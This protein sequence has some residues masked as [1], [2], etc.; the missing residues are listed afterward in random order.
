[1]NSN[2]SIQAHET[3]EEKR[4]L[5][6]RMEDAMRR[7]A[8][9]DETAFET[10]LSQYEKAVYNL[11]YQMLSCEQDAE[12]AAQESF[13]KLW[14]TLPAFR[15]DCSPYT[16]IMKIAQNVCLDMLRHRHGIQPDS[17]TASDD[18]TEDS[19]QTDIIDP[20]PTPPETAVQDETLREAQAALAALPPEQR[21]ILTLREINGCDY[22]TIAAILGKP[23]GSVKSS[24]SRARDALRKIYFNR[25]PL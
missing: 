17:L 16:W 20:D 7:A 14:K 2:N 21:E 23:I 11:A 22:D 9:G 10:L 19:I 4:R 24:L 15:F 12:D 8:L 3:D 5:R 6:H 18:D 25:N 1:V 13:L